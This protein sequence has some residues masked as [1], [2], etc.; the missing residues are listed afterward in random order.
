M[1]LRETIT[2]WF[3]HKNVKR[4]AKM[5]FNLEFIIKHDCLFYENL[6][7]FIILIRKFSRNYSHFLIYTKFL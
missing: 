7:S 3:Q 2:L 6:A 1:G 4:L 5:F